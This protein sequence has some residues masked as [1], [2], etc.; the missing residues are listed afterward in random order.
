MRIN[1]TGLEGKVL[2]QGDLDLLMEEHGFERATWD[3]KQATYDY[4]YEDRQTGHIMY[5]RV[6]SIAI[7][8]VIEENGHAVLELKQPYIGKHI[9]PHGMDYEYDFP[10]HIMKHALQTLQSIVDQMQPVS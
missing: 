8:G 4:T 10:Q 1:D 7:E 6:P 5:L 2:D 9:Y 3:Y